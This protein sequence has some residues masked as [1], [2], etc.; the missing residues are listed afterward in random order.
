MLRSSGRQRVWDLPT[1]LGH[2][3]LALLVTGSLITGQVAGTWIEWHGYFGLGIIWLLSFRL[4]WGVLGSTYARLGQFFPTPSRLIAYARGQWHGLGHSPLG[5]LSVFS[6][7]S[8]LILQAGAGLFAADD[9][10][11]T[12]PLRSRASH[13]LAESLT[14]WHRLTSNLV[15]GLV[16]LHLAAIAWYQYRGKKLIAA[17]IDG[18]AREG[19]G[20]LAR[21][22]GWLA[23]VI[24]LTL[25]S[26]LT[27]YVSGVW[28]VPEPAVVTPAW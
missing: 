5:A 11:F 7:L 19:H 25:A 20:A 26:A 4:V 12:G 16:A 6:L 21:G 28:I 9:T 22:G 10:G 3:S 1:R 27:W 2:W 15:F 23:L 8:V 17:M 13:E 18:Y 24:A 14:D